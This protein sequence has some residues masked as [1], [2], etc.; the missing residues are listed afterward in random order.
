MDSSD[1]RIPE[2]YLK[3]LK[4]H[5]DDYNVIDQQYNELSESRRLK[6][7]VIRN[8]ID[9]LK[10]SHGESAFLASLDNNGMAK[11]ASRFLTID[12]IATA[13]RKT[14]VRRRKGSRSATPVAPASIVPK[15][16]PIKLLSGKYEGWTGTITTS[17]AKQGRYGLDVTYFLLLRGPAGDVR[18]T[19]VKHGTLG[20]SWQTQD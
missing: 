2:I 16:T 11:A 18:R 8:L 9:F 19:S 5:I 1:N 7:K 14:V 4:R 3:D 20:K 15:G 12:N 17:Q 10:G 6:G 13:G